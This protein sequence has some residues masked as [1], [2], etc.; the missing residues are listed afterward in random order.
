MQFPV[1]LRDVNGIRRA[2][3]HLQFGLSIGAA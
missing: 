3:T 2:A 1:T